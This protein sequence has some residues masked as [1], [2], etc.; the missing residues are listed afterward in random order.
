MRVLTVR[1]PW[2]ELIVSGR[3]DVENRTWAT[4]YRGPLLIHAGA[5]F[6]QGPYLDACGVPPDA[7]AHATRGAFVGIVELVDC[8]EQ[9]PSLWA[10][11]G[12]YH[13]VL[14]RAR[15]VPAVAC[16]GQLGLWHPPSDIL[17]KLPRNV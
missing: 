11:E 16:A 8:V 7:F 1:Q 5:A 10:I 17:Q 6:Y 12:H 14:R 4:K 3:K 13:W 2:A 9:H 15:R